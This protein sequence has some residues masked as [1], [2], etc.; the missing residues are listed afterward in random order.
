VE[1]FFYPVFFRDKKKRER[2]ARP[3]VFTKGHALILSFKVLEL[4]KK[5]KPLYIKNP[6]WYKTKKTI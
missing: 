2:K 1:L 5:N 6:K 3:E 4:S